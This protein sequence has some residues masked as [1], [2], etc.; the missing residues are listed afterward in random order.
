MPE[1]SDILNEVRADVQESFEHVLERNRRSFVPRFHESDDDLRPL[2]SDAQRVAAV[3]WEFDCV[4]VGT[5]LGIPATFL[6]LTLR[7]ATFVNFAAGED[8]NTWGFRRYIDYLGALNQLGVSGI[9]RPVLTDEQ[10]E[11]WVENN[12]DRRGGGPDPTE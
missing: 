8:P 9:Q 3:P 10:Y 11:T 6:E 12:R 7:G 5:F 4:H 1:P 2:V